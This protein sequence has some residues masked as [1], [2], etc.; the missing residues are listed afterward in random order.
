MT[1]TTST[2]VETAPYLDRTT[3]RARLIV[4]GKPFL[5]LGIEL[6]NSSSSGSGALERGLLAAQAVNANT[7]LASVTWESVEPTQGSFDF[8]SVDGLVSEA[9][10]SGMRLVLLWFGAWKNGS[11][12][13]APAWVKRDWERYPRCVLEDGRLSDTL[14]PFGPTDLDADAFHALVAHVEAIDSDH[15]TVLMIQIENEIGLLGSSRD[16]SEWA[17]TAFQSPIPTD[18]QHALAH[19]PGF[20]RDVP[21]S[22][23]DVSGDPLGRDE[24]FM[25]W[26]YASH[27]ERLASRARQVTD[28]PLFVN[29]WLDSEIDV[30]IE[31]FAVAGGQVPGTY[32]SGGPLPRVADVWTTTA[33][34]LDLLAPDFYF[35]DPDA[36]LGSF[37]EVS[38]GLFIPEQRRDLSGIGTAF[39]AIGQYRAIGVSPFGVDSAESPEIVALA[40]AYRLLAAGH[41]V[42]PNAASAGFHL[43]DASP[44]V[45]RTFGR[46]VLSISRL[47]GI[48]VDPSGAQG[49]GIVMELGEDDFLAIGRGFRIELSDTAPEWQVGLESVEELDSDGRCARRLNG[50]E[51]AGGTAI[52]HPPAERT[53]SP[54]PIPM[55]HAHTGITRF[56]AY[57]LPRHH[58]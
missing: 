21:Q 25:A 16:H 26:G 29:A 39:L 38:E 36:V 37:A 57:R 6:H 41:A 5:V 35:G 53:A 28:L 31:G 24:A 17:D 7:V 55:D 8:A 23:S 58:P 50:D 51:T 47:T 13:Y 34:S 48:G 2:A 1:T 10:R 33:P 40:D 44:F 52:L 49:Y 4:D 42:G 9:R 45:I 56:T 19:R 11:S 54:F 20:E 32:P 12:S 14:T 3:G 27:V 22:W 46:T 30:D 18:L 15:R 43:S